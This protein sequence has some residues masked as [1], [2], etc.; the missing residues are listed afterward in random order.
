MT[1]SDSLLFSVLWVNGVAFFAYGLDKWQAKRGG[2]RFSERLLLFLAAIGGS[3][4]AYLAMYLF[5][6]KTLHKKFTY[7]VPLLFL[8][9]VLAVFAAYEKGLLFF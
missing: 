3:I 4:G 7:G 6:H 1:P 8:L 2:W 9:Q 5:H